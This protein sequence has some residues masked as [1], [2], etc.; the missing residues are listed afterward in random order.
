MIENYATT[1]CLQVYIGSFQFRQPGCDYAI[2][3][4]DHLTTN[5]CNEYFVY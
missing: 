3:A 5:N 1:K 4:I 2:T